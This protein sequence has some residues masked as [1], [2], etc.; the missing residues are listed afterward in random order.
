MPFYGSTLTVSITPTDGEG[1]SYSKL[2][3]DKPD[4]GFSCGF[5]NRKGWI[6][7]SVGNRVDFEAFARALSKDD[8]SVKFQ[9][10]S[11][12]LQVVYE[13]GHTSP[14]SCVMWYPD[15]LPVSM[16]TDFEN[17]AFL[18]PYAPQ[19]SY[20]PFYDFCLMGPRLDKLRIHRIDNIKL[21]RAEIGGSNLINTPVTCNPS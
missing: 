17:S 8:A 2:I 5:N 12:N 15:K 10:G 3:E 11:G 18:T 6:S 9:T 20:D 21:E 1:I 13:D 19:Q 16:R 14:E 4:S 7:V